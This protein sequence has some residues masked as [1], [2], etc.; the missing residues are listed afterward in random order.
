MDWGKRTMVTIG[1]TVSHALRTARLRPPRDADSPDSIQGWECIV[2][3]VTCVETPMFAG[4]Y[5]GDP[6]RHGSSLIAT[7]H[8]DTEAGLDVAVSRPWQMVCYN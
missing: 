4:K 2:P 1:T 5:G 6:H 7:T 3:I 8:D